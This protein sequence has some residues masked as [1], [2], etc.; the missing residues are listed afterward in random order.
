MQRVHRGITNYNLV[1]WTFNCLDKLI[2]NY[3]RLH[4]CPS[5]RV[6][7]DDVLVAGQGP[8]AD[9]R[10]NPVILSSF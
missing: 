8:A 4:L 9:C 1:I 3:F 7:N 5:H 6:L 10:H 2:I